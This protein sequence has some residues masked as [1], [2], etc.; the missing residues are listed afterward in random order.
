M[1]PPAADIARILKRKLPLGR[2]TFRRTAFQG[3]LTLS[4][5]Q[6]SPSYFFGARIL[7]R[8]DPHRRSPFCR[9]ACQGCHT[10]ANGLLFPDTIGRPPG[11]DHLLHAGRP[12]SAA[13]RRVERSTKTICAVWILFDIRR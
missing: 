9:T 3:R 4:D 13:L 1:I 7:K 8:K 10:S 5:G 2:S 6:G 11:L 12:S